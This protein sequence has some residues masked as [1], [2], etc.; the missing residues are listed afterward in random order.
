M[1]SVSED[2]DSPTALQPNF[3]QLYQSISQKLIDE[4]GPKLDI[5]ALESQVEQTS[6]EINSIRSN[7]A[8]QLAQ[9]ITSMSIL[10]S[11]Y[12]CTTIA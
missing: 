1:S 3:D 7:F 12:N 2:R 9:V 8:D 10:R 4:M 11:K 5:S 6:V